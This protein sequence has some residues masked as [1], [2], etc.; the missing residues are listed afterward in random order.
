MREQAKENERVKNPYMRFSINFPADDKTPK[1]IRRQFLSN[2]MS[3]M[4]VRTDNHIALVVKHNDKH[5][6]YHITVNRIGFDGQTLSDSHSK[7]RL[8]VAVD[9]WEKKMELDNSLEKSRAFIYDPQSELGYRIKKRETNLLKSNKNKPK[10]PKKEYVQRNVLEIIRE[11]KVTSPEELKAKLIERKINFEFT[12]NKNGLSGTSF[13]YDGYAF[14]GSQIDFKAGQL[15][16]EFE[17]NKEVSLQTGYT[18]EERERFK[19]AENRIREQ[20]K[21]QSLKESLVSCDIDVLIRREVAGVKDPSAPHWQQNVWKV[22]SELGGDGWEEKLWNYSKQMSAEYNNLK[23]YQQKIVERISL[24]KLK[25][26]V[27]LES[28]NNEEETKPQVQ[29]KEDAERKIHVSTEPTRPEQLNPKQQQLNTL[30]EQEKQRE[31]ERERP[32]SKGYRR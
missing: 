29:Q 12:T 28:G 4:G 18:P 21:L 1:N 13:R 20:I 22:S 2:V 32:K 10:E 23:P 16:A 19:I 30:R 8:E 6:H 24:D 26:Y 7:R 3:E 9:K 25:K 17:R 5:P 15:K 27:P 31:Q 11:H 14:K